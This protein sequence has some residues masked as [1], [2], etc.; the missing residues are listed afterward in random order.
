LKNQ[1]C[2]TTRFYPIVKSHLCSQELKWTVLVTVIMYA[3]GTRITV[4]HSPFVKRWLPVSAGCRLA[5]CSCYRYLLCTCVS[6]CWSS[7]NRKTGLQYSGYKSCGLFRVDSIAT[8]CVLSQNFRHWPAE[9]H[10]SRL[11]D[12]ARLVI[13]QLRT[14][15]MMVI[16]AK[17]A[18]VEFCLN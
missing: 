5:H 14:M 6:M 1:Y 13:N 16:K 11:L 9:M 3:A 15:L 8:D 18:H 10:D 17:S 12:S 2:T 4:R 7:L